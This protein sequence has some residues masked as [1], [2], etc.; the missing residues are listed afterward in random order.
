MVAYSHAVYPEN[1]SKFCYNYSIC[2][3]CLLDNR[4]IKMCIHVSTLRNACV[5]TTSSMAFP[6]RLLM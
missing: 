2:C 6:F 3:E 1:S 4:K 5:L